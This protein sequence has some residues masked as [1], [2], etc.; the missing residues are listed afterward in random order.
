MTSRKGV[1]QL[2]EHRFLGMKHVLALVLVIV[3]PLGLATTAFARGGLAGQDIVIL[4]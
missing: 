2:I 1:Q 3:M 4:I